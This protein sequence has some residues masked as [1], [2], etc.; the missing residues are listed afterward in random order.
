MK[1]YRGSI[2]IEVDRRQSSMQGVHNYF[3]RYIFA[4]LDP[5]RITPSSCTLP[6]LWNT[7]QSSI[8]SLRHN[9]FRASTCSYKTETNLMSTSMINMTPKWA[10]FKIRKNT[11]TPPL[12][13]FMRYHMRSTYHSFMDYSLTLNYQ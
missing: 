6:K 4:C 2:W 3:L 11:E 10:V 8:P 12:Y 5:N 1:T 7:F 9:F 13:T